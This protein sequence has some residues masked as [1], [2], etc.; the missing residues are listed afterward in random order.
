MSSIF[1]Q[2][3]AA[4]HEYGDAYESTRRGKYQE[5][6]RRLRRCKQEEF[7]EWKLID[8]ALLSL[9]ALARV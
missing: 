4:E 9:S 8:L 7:P 5:C 6:A 3:N 1:S 2:D